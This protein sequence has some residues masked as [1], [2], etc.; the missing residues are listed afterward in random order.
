[1]KVHRNL[2]RNPRALL[3]WFVEELLEKRSGVVAAESDDEEEAIVDADCAAGGG[4][5]A[6]LCVRPEFVR[7]LVV[8]FEEAVK[9]KERS[10]HAA[11]SPQ[12][13]C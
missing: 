8:M 5:A 9:V 6:K 12:G 2:R 1:M 3:E 10:V 7:S 13:P 11:S 4:R